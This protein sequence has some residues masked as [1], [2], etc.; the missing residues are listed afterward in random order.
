VLLLLASPGRVPAALRTFGLMVV[1]GVLVNA[2]VT[3][4]ISQPAA[5]YGARVAWLIPVVA[6][7]FVMVTMRSGG[8]D[9]GSSG[10]EGAVS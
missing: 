5:R 7:I 10:D 1:L 4:A 2:F 6:V 8:R 3:G 9:L